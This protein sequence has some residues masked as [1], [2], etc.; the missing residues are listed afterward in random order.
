VPGTPQRTHPRA[1]RRD[2]LARE[3]P[4]RMGAEGIQDD[5]ESWDDSP[6]AGGL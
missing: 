4:S 2:R 5:R 1:A 3:L 6:M